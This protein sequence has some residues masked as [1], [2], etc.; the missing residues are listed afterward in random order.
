MFQAVCKH[1]SQSDTSGH[2]AFAWQRLTQG[3]R[4]CGLEHCAHSQALSD[5][6]S[7]TGC[8]QGWV[9]A[10]QCLCS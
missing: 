3:L 9:L 1:A 7:S 8:W 6:V 10:L 5:L 4:D 2:L